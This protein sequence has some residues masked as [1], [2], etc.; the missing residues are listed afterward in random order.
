MEVYLILDIRYLKVYVLIPR[1]TKTAVSD[2]FMITEDTDD[3]LGIDNNT[4]L[5]NYTIYE[6]YKT[7][8]TFWPEPY[9]FY[10]QV[11]KK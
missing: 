8:N 7:F 6:Y 4:N 11:M 1:S 5:T 2:K 10:K 3:I 9:E